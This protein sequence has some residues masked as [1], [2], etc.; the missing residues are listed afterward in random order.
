VPLLTHAVLMARL[1]NIEENVPE[2]E[3]N[4]DVNDMPHCS[5]EVVWQI[6]QSLTRGGSSL[7]EFFLLWLR[8]FC[9]IGGIEC[10]L[11]LR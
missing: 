6:D 7:S 2:V 5:K 9:S 10:P 3:G 1:E 4:D 8:S 11:V